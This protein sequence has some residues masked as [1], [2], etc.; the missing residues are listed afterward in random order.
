[1]ALNQNLVTLGTINSGATAIQADVSQGLGS[2]ASVEITLTTAYTLASPRPPG[3]PFRP[4]MTGAQ[5]SNL[6]APGRVLNSGTVL[7]V[8][9]PEATAL[10]N[11][12]AATLG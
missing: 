12:S 2:A 1:M 11:A 10:I 4:S 7:E 6:D 5:F 8:L 3:W 9:Q